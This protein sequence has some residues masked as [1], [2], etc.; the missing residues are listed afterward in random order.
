MIV[1]KDAKGTQAVDTLKKKTTPAPVVALDTARTKQAPISVDTA[2][3][4]KPPPDTAA[5]AGTPKAQQK[6]RKPIDSRSVDIGELLMNRYPNLLVWSALVCLMVAFSMACVP[7]F[8]DQWLSM[9]VQFEDL[10]LALGVNLLGA[11]AVGIVMVVVPTGLPGV[12]TPLD[13]GKL[14][15]TSFE[16]PWVFKGPLLFT[17]LC[18]CVGIG[19]MFSIGSGLIRLVNSSDGAMDVES[20]RKLSERFEVL[21]NALRLTLYLMALMVAFA[22]FTS[23][24]MR[25]SLNAMIRIKEGDILFP[26]EFVN[27]YGLFF[28]AILALIYLPLHY[29]LGEA[30]AAIAVRLERV[31]ALA[32][33]LPPPPPAA[34][35][36]P[37]PNPI[38]A[39]IEDAL[40]KFK[41]TDKG[42][43]NL[44][45]ALSILA[46]ALT[47]L[48][49]KYLPV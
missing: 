37:P 6:P 27:I 18:A 33:A 47:A 24:N 40:K 25:I 41:L 9:R 23:N 36:P 20:V 42:L 16:S 34:A 29:K 21:N 12:W 49:T 39:T 44:K 19:V 38:I 15:A 10:E 43:D 7:V 31:K 5:K 1:G 46:P 45:L 14:L 11:L 4:Q 35:P 22:V 2:K 8:I 26:P 30:G 17:G 32:A 48:L 13:Y 28:S 3:T